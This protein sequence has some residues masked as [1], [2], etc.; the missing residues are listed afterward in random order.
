MYHYR[1]KRMRK[2]MFLTNLILNII[3]YFGKIYSPSLHQDLYRKLNESFTNFTP[4]N[5]IQNVLNEENLHYLLE[6]L[7][8]DKNCEDSKPKK[9]HIHQ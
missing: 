3:N 6:E 2:I 7:V 9:K 8:N 1:T 5:L 4:I